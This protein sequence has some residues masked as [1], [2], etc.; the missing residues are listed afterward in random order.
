[1]SGKELSL[2]ELLM[3]GVEEIPEQEESNK[4]LDVKKSV[5]SIT[6][7]MDINELLSNQED[8]A[9]EINKPPDEGEK[10]FDKETEGSNSETPDSSKNTDHEDDESQVPFPLAF[11]RYQLE[12]GNFTDLNEEELLKVI[13]EEGDA[14]ALSYLQNKEIER[15]RNE[16]LDTYED[17]VKYYL[18]MLDS[19]VEPDTAKSI[20]KAK[21]Y[22]DKLNINDVE[23][24]D[25]EDLRKEIMTQYY[26]LTTKF[27]DVKIKKEIENKIA[28]G[29]DIEFAKEAVPEIKDYFKQVGEEEKTKIEQQRVENEKLNKQRIEEFNK[30]IED[31][32]EVVPGV[33]LNKNEKSKIREIITKPVKEVNGVPLNS[34]WAKRSEDPDKFDTVL[35]TLYHYGVFDGK[36]D[37]LVKANKSKAAEEIEKA[38]KGGAANF[39]SGFSRTKTSPGKNTPESASLDAMRGA[40][41]DFQ[42]K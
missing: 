11:A 29:E 12:Q 17:D 36:W 15:A 28:L 37:K 30:K 10:E 21:S 22:Y 23:Q 13:E 3:Q 25:K 7:E 8:E 38:M 14:A 18:D 35:A 4:E 42:S 27:S 40:F 32:Q 9:E 2:E 16:L 41:G 6:D 26:K 24:E 19:G 31:L 1:M 34:L 39:K 33:K 20:S 5:P